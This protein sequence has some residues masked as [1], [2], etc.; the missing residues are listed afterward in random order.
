MAMKDAIVLGNTL[1]MTFQNGHI[2][3]AL[4]VYEKEMIERASKS[5]VKS[6]EATFPHPGFFEQ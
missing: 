6:R 5:V 4:K 3:D 2:E 1:S